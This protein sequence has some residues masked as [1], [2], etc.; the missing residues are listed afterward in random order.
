MIDW[1]TVVATFFGPILAILITRWNDNRKQNYNEKLSIFK[2]L[3][4]ARGNQNNVFFVD[5]INVIDVVFYKEQKIVE[6]KNEFV[7]HR[8]VIGKDNWTANDLNIWAQKDRKNLNCLLKAIAKNINIT[9]EGIGDETSVFSP[10]WL[11]T[12]NQGQISFGELATYLN[13]MKQVQADH[14]T[15]SPTQNI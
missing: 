15:Q 6:L 9:I 5:A 3:M 12:C 11:N 8:F 10:A 4:S 14:S 13:H 2:T 1:G 7:G